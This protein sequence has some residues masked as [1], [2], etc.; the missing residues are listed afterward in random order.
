MTCRRGTGRVA[1]AVAS[2]RLLLGQV[3]RQAYRNLQ[4]DRAGCQEPLPTRRAVTAQVAAPEA[5]NW[6]AAGPP[7][8]RAFVRSLDEKFISGV[9]ETVVNVIRFFLPEG[10]ED[11]PEVRQRF[12]RRPARRV[13]GWRAEVEGG[14]WCRR[15]LSWGGMVPLRQYSALRG[16][17]QASCLECAIPLLPVCLQ[18]AAAKRK[19]LVALSR[20][21]FTEYFG[22]IRCGGVAAGA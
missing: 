17:I 21:L 5:W 14:G 16:Q 13:K 20:E 10:S 2:P 3:G 18:A 15:R 6:T 12:R 1:A 4:Y 9:Q 11:S 22:I 19:P 7:P 8:L